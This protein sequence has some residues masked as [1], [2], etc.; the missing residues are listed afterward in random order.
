M[1]IFILK[2]PKQSQL[3]I[4]FAESIWDNTENIPS[5]VDDFVKSFVIEVIEDT[6]L[7]EKI[8]NL[9]IGEHFETPSGVRGVRQA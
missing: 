2:E 9:K 4:D 6:Q 5:N 8:I 7:K 3:H 1:W